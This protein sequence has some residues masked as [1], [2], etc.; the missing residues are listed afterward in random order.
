MTRTAAALV[1]CTAIPLAA[2]GARVS[3]ASF[4]EAP[5]KPPGHEIRLYSTRLPTC[6]YE[7]IG[8]VRSQRGQFGSLDGALDALKRRARDMGGDAVVGLGQGV[9]VAG[10]TAIGDVSTVSSQEVLAGT[11]IRFTD[12]GCVP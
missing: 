9:S 3:S 4:V 7:E 5:P 10:G 12:A 1:F 6:P 2:C 8:L 11:V